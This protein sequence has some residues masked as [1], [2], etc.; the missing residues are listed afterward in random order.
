MHF[1]VLILCQS[2]Q[3]WIKDRI[4]FLIK[5]KI[6]CSVWARFLYGSHVTVKKLVRD[7]ICRPISS[8]ELLFLKYGSYF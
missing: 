3:S 6:S 1:Q 8:K 7:F 4:R 2:G 5:Y